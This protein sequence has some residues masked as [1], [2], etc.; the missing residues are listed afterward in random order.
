MHLETATMSEVFLADGASVK[1]IS[2]LCESMQLEVTSLCVPFMTD[3]TL[4]R[5]VS[6]VDTRVHLLNMGPI[7]ILKADKPS[8]NNFVAFDICSP[9]E[10]FMED[11][12]H[13]RLASTMYESV[14][15]EI[16]SLRELFIANLLCGYE[17]A[18]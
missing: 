9:S 15:H 3:V 4:T 16:A 8:V 10:L 14:T 6:S 13:M 7:K 12:K 17:N 1:C 5:L 18:S 2:F 11:R